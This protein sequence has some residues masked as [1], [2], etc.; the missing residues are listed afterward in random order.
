MLLNFISV[1]EN[2]IICL[3]IKAVKLY[4]QIKMLNFLF[5]LERNKFYQ[6]NLFV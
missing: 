4:F 1:G 3:I 6:F 2:T 5:L